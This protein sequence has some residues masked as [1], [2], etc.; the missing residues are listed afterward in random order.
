VS[1]TGQGA[2]GGT[3]HGVRQKAFARSS[4]PHGGCRPRRPRSLE[5]AS[6]CQRAAPLHMPHAETKNEHVSAVWISPQ[7][8]LIGLAL[9][10][11]HGIGPS[12][13]SVKAVH[14]DALGFLFTLVRRGPIR[15]HPSPVHIGACT[16][17]H[18]H[19]HMHTRARARAHT[20]NYSR[21]GIWC[22]MQGVNGRKDT[23]SGTPLSS[24]MPFWKQ[25]SD[26]HLSHSH[27]MPG[28]ACAHACADGLQSA[29]A[30]ASVPEV[31][32]WLMKTL[33]PMEPIFSSRFPNS[34]P[35]PRPS[36]SQNTD[37]HF[38]QRSRT[39]TRSQGQP[40]D[41][42]AHSELW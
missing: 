42:N 22:G 26:C 38:H 25:A 41:A 1:V 19:T 3:A 6:R 8:R 2:G 27:A 36:R 40:R 32:S 7:L 35:H 29:S 10:A 15:T 4:S 34:L 31:V 30:T 12:G 9:W 13:S 5:S 18:T 14:V 11:V 28:R 33:V 39:R 37:S 24:A 21:L 17:T 23:T 16:H 20:H